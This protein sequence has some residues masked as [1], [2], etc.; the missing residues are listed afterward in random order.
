MEND[1]E[2]LQDIIQ[3][4]YSNNKDIQFGDIGITEYN[5]ALYFYYYVSPKDK[6]IAENGLFKI[7]SILK[8]I[9]GK[10]HSDHIV[11]NTCYLDLANNIY[12]PI[13][14]LYKEYIKEIN[15]YV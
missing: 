5:N 13:Y 8:L 11:C 3:N 10:M 6:E 12:E 15:Y 1:L 4:E 2:I 14:K 9:V 7:N